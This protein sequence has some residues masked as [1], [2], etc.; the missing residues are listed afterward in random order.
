MLS[1]AIV[2]SF[3][4]YAV[5]SLSFVMAASALGL[6]AG[7]LVLGFG[8]YRRGWLGGG[9]AKLLAAGMAWAG[10]PL[11]GEYLAVTGIVGGALAL[12]LRWPRTA[13]CADALRRNWPGTP[14]QKTASMP[15]GVA[16]AAGAVAV[17]IELLPR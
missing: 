11:V 16:I 2:A 13:W 3:G 6:A 10:L 1:V 9:D 8:A 12:A 5:T 7:T 17:A 4:V 14:A 15:Y